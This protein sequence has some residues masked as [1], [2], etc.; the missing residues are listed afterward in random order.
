[1]QKLVYETN[2]EQDPDKVLSIIFDPYSRKILNS[3][4]NSFKS[5][6]EISSICK[7]PISTVYR[8]LH[9]LYE[10]NM[11]KKSGNIGLDGKKYFLYKSKMYSIRVNF[12]PKS[13]KVDLDWNQKNPTDSI[14]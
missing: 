4:K 1:M 14:L 11:L 7:V 9:D 13:L 12:T 8:R 5:P 2:I 6:H 3:I 10:I